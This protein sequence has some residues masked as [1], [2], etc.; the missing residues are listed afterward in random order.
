VSPLA[1]GARRSP[2]KQANQW[3][4]YSLIAGVKNPSRKKTLTNDVAKTYCSSDAAILEY[5]H[6]FR[7]KSYDAGRN[8]EVVSRCG[9]NGASMR[10][11]FGAIETARLTWLRRTFL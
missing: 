2:R 10:W 5:D 1:E 9:K 6:P 11:L 7:Q 8:R 4:L 3:S